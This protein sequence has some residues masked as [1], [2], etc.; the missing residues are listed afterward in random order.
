MDNR[1]KKELSS[2]QKITNKQKRHDNYLS[3]N[4]P[5]LKEAKKIRNTNLALVFL[6]RQT[7]HTKEPVTIEKFC[8]Q[9]NIS[10]ST[11]RNIIKELTG[12][13][14]KKTSKKIVQQLEQK[15]SEIKI[16]N[17]P[18]KHKKKYVEEYDEDLSDVEDNVLKISNIIDKDPNI[19]ING[20]IE[21]LKA[22]ALKR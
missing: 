17:P 19:Q 12:V 18:K 20:K 2:F 5:T 4:L 8:S 16:K 10:K 3:S 1:K 14:S 7:D 13:K 11:L 15:I 6:E 22:E 21:K 9:N